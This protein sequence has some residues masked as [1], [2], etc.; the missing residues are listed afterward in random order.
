MSREKKVQTINIVKII[1]IIML[2]LAL[3]NNPYVY[4][5]ILRWVIAGVSAYSVYLAYKQSKNTWVW[6]LIIIM[7]LFNPITPI[8]FS[9]KTW[10]FLDIIAALVIFISIFKIKITKEKNHIKR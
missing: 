4:Y 3:S 6:I 9:K 5:Q 1:A 8:H 7:I 2:F 10:L